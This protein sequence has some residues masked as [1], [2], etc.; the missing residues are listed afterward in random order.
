MVL[1]SRHIHIHI[2]HPVTFGSPTR[3]VD[4]FTG[5]IRL[6]LQDGTF[7]H[8]NFSSRHLHNFSSARHLFKN[9]HNEHYLFRTFCVLGSVKDCV[10][11]FYSTPVVSVF[12]SSN[13]TMVFEDPCNCCHLIV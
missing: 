12:S 9:H 2:P 6:I 8:I 3:F 10:V 1:K 11:L 7:H 4:G 5:F 13:F